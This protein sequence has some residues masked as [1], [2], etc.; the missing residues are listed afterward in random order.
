MFCNIDCV[1]IIF[2]KDHFFSLVQ[3]DTLKQGKNILHLNKGKTV[4]NPFPLFKCVDF[5]IIWSYALL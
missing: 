5:P 4:W 1:D 2:H 3:V